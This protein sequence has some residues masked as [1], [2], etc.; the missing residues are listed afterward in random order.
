M[1]DG[2]CP[3]RMVAVRTP[4]GAS[5]PLASMNLNWWGATE[6]CRLGHRFDL[7]VSER[8]RCMDPAQ[9]GGSQGG[10]LAV[11]YQPNA[12]PGRICRLAQN[13]GGE[14][15]RGGE[16]EHPIGPDRDAAVSQG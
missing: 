2:R 4:I 10:P 3:D 15:E 13:L 14:P 11:V 9:R 12:H 5:V 1:R 8:Q 16:Q 6:G 7:E